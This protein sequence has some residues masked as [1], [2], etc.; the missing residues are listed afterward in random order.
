MREIATEL[1]KV[2]QPI[3]A[4]ARDES[5]DEY[6]ERFKLS[7]EA[8]TELFGE[9]ISRAGG[10]SFDDPVLAYLEEL[11]IRRREIEDHMRLTIAYAREF[12]RPEPYRLRV[13]ADAAR[14]SI[15]GVRTA[16]NIDDTALIA[17][18][19][20]RSDKRGEVSPSRSAL[21][22]STPAAEQEWWAVA[23]D[24]IV[25]EGNTTEM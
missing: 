22:A 2:L 6:E 24:S 8:Q 10:S 15:S 25:P 19:I 3:P 13:L 21:I 14:M 17:T 12:V 16:Y 7:K 18:R 11:A 20:L 1:A 9:L 23:S 4:K 5:S